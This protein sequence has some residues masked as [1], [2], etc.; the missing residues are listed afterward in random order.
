M[1]NHIMITLGLRNNKQ[2]ITPLMNATI[3]T[4]V[5]VTFI[6][7]QVIEEEPKC[8]PRTTAQLSAFTLYPTE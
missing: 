1:L 3:T 5:T 8:Q 7:K 2:F 6:Q 4:S